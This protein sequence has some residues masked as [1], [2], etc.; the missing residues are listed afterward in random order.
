M[1]AARRAQAEAT[2]ARGVADTPRRLDVLL[3]E[4]HQDLRELLATRLRRRGWR[5]EEASNGAGALAR[6][7]RR[8]LPDVVL[9]D[10][11][12]PGMDGYA[13]AREIR[14]DRRLEHLRLV[15]LTG[16]GGGA[17]AA[18]AREAGFDVHLVKPVTLEA[19]MDALTG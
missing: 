8:S 15:A 14:S 17:S 4:D 7:R 11:G 16:Y 9:T 18:K 12:L 1:R 5:V 3:V 19:L 13:L 10:V 6:L 2:R